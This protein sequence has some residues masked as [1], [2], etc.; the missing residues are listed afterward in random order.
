MAFEIITAPVAMLTDYS[1]TVID[2]RSG[3]FAGAATLGNATGNTAHHWGSGRN[4][5]VHWAS[6]SRNAADADGNHEQR[7]IRGG[8]GVQ[9]EQNPGLGTQR[10]VRRSSAQLEYEFL[11]H[12]EQAKLV[13]TGSTGTDVE[14]G[15]SV[16]LS[17]DGNT[18]AIGGPQDNSGVGAVWIFIRVPGATT[19]TQQGTKLVATSA[20]DEQQGRSVALS[21]DGNTL[22]VG[23]IGDSAGL[24]RA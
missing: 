10:M 2:S 20:A 19:W 11:C 3:A 18:L 21:S 14:Q 15:D 5:Q 1:M 16:A 8:S 4:A 9:P 23:A 6:R 7:F 24:G 12:D 17:S 13:G 22:A